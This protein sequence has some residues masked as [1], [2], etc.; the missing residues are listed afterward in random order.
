MGVAFQHIKSGENIAY[1]PGFTAQ[2]MEKQRVNLGQYKFQYNYGK[3]EPIDIPSSTLNGSYEITQNILNLL[4]NRVLN[5]L[6][7]KD[8]SL[9]HQYYF[10]YIY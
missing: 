10:Y 2:I 6:C 7:Q 1:F 3:Y 8:I 4:S 9:D 5:I